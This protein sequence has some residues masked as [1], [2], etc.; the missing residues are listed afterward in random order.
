MN[1]IIDSVNTKSIELLHSEGRIVWK[2][3]AW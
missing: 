3:L 2:K 1:N